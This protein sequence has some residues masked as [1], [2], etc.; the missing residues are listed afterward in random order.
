MWESERN[1]LDHSATRVFFFVASKIT[2]LIGHAQIRPPEGPH[3]IWRGFAYNHIGLPYVA[4]VQLSL[5]FTFTKKAKTSQNES[6]ETSILADGCSN[7]SIA[8]KYMAIYSYSVLEPLSF[9]F[10]FTKKAITSQ[11]ESPENKHFG[12]SDQNTSQSTVVQFWNHFLCCLPL[13]KKR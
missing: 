2:A 4:V 5:L 11:N 13:P 8:S 9:L 1:R 6:P 3:A 12:R 10:T 7:P